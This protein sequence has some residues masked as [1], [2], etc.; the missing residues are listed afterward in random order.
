MPAKLP[1]GYGR[2]HRSTPAGVRCRPPTPWQGGGS[3][4]TGRCALLRSF[5]S[6][7]HSIVFR[8]STKDEIRNVTE[9]ENVTRFLAGPHPP[10]G[11]AGQCGGVPGRRRRFGWEVRLQLRSLH[12]KTSS[13][14][15]FTAPLF[16]GRVAPASFGVH[17]V[18]AL[19][20]PRFRGKSA[21]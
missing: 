20:L 2:G 1:R 21:R 14:A 17:H 19:Y 8:N 11:Q 15:G 16:L 6:C 4:G 13:L 12:G 18:A 7:S 5:H 9:Y 3:P 10:K